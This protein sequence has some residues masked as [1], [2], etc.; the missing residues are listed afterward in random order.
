M[1]HC[2]NPYCSTPQ[3]PDTAN[4]CCYCGFKLLLGD[5]YRALE[6][7]GRGGFG[8]TFLAVDEYKPSRPKCVIK[9]FFPQNQSSHPEQ[10]RELFQREAIQLER[11]GD[12]PQIPELL[13]HFEQADYLY[14]VQ[15]YIDG[16]NLLQRLAR[17]GP[18]SDRQVWHLLHDLLPVLDFIHNNQVIHRDVKPQNVIQR[19]NG[20]YV[21]VDFGAAKSIAGSDLPRTGTSIG[22][23]EFV[24]PEQA[25]GKAVYASDLYSLGVTCI[26]LMT[27]VRP[28]DLFDTDEGVW[29]WQQHV[30]APVSSALSQLLDKLL[31]GPIK[32]RYQSASEVLQDLTGDR[33]VQALTRESVGVDHSANQSLAPVF[34]A[35]TSSQ[36][37]ISPIAPTAPKVWK[38]LHRLTGHSS[39]VRAV[40]L[41]PEG[42]T[43]ASGSGD[44]TLKF[45][46]LDGG[47]LL[48]TVVAH[49][50]WVR[51]IAASPD[52]RMV[53]SCS[54]DK[55][56]KIWDWQTGNCLG[57]FRGHGDWV[58]SLAFSSN[59]K[60][61]VS[62]SQDRT[63]KVW[64]VATGELLQTLEG[65]SHWVTAIGL[66]P[67]GQTLVS[68]S[69]DKTLY[70]WH[71]SKPQPLKTL[72]GHT[73]SINTVA[74]SADN[75]L[76]AS[77]SDDTTVRLWD[78]TSGRLKHTLTDHRGAVH[79]VVFTP[80]GSALI[81][82]SQDGSVKIWDLA[83]GHL[84]HTLSDHANWIWSVAVARDGATIVA[85]CWDG[86]IKIWRKQS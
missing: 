79:S 48:R 84:L 86:S 38:C 51:A 67:D 40:A 47:E 53:G 19:P 21:L 13:A 65:H 70:L 22:S 4:F 7:L 5:R 37:T 44:K 56:I 61:L 17:R 24:A 64:H 6:S 68:G 25:I 28:A 75:S 42:N 41:H 3:N 14:L 62:G 43:L 12:H 83:T 11:L 2:L 58:R 15:E 46:R 52:G 30:Q 18:F 45:W 78:L 66:S 20:Q 63:V 82:G 27:R 85:G 49:E 50:A 26:Y 55:T 77:G 23:P 57:T 34:E 35:A 16:E 10:A 54:N 81:S 8:R 72:E 1:S 59:G 74:I 76:L 31:Q 71:P 39:W 60:L 33:I 29:V 9:Q 73:S 32:R 36:T 69:R 80:D